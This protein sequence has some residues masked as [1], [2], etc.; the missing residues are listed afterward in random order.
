MRLFDHF[1][2][3]GK[4]K[5]PICGTSDDKPCFLMPIDG[6]QKGY[7]AEAA[8]THADCIREDLDKFA[9]QRECGIVYMRCPA[10]RKVKG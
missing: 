10:E 8:P 3:H 7:T 4:T 2:Q 5:C 1:P 6:T 9:Y